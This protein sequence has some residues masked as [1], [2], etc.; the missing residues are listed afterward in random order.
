MRPWRYQLTMKGR[1]MIS[2]IV[3]HLNA[4]TAV[5]FAALILS[6]AGGAFAFGGG[7]GPKAAPKATAGGRTATVAV[8]TAS[9]AKSKGTR[10]PR[11]PKG[12]QGPSGSAG[13]AGPTGPAGPAGPAGPTGPAGAKGETGPAGPEGPP[14]KD[15]K[16]GSPWTAGG[17]LPSGKTETGTWTFTGTVA[18]KAF[19]ALSFPIPLPAGTAGT[20]VLNE[21]HVHFFQVGEGGNGTP[22]N[23]CGSGTA[24]KPEAEKGNL[25]VYLNYATSPITAEI[26][27]SGNP[28][29]AAGAG[30]TGANLKIA[31]SEPEARGEG[32]W[33]V[34]A[35]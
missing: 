28:G 29:R 20:P 10:G 4:T 11:G 31:S 9:K 3:Q 22:G 16:E 25:C 34:S 12:P 13:P 17:T 19:V 18:E 5:A 26:L 27:D 8:A 6:M 24:E 21:E 23:G 1:P 7:S 14:G 15:G 2:R 30:A 32:T 35:E 33:A